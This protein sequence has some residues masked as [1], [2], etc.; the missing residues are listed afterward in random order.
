MNILKVAK[1]GFSLH[2]AIFI[3]VWGHGTSDIQLRQNFRANKVYLLQRSGNLGVRLSQIFENSFRR[4]SHLKK[5][6]TVRI[7]N[8]LTIFVWDNLF[9]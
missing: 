1:S 6:A 8:N 3:V 7:V 9:L 4:F 2:A 5:E